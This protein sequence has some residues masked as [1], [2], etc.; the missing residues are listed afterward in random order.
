MVHKQIVII[1]WY[2]RLYL[3]YDIEFVASKEYSRSSCS[4]S[5]SCLDIDKKV[6]HASRGR[7]APS[8]LPLALLNQARCLNLIMEIFFNNH[9]TRVQYSLL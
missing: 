7:E 6:Q 9:F 1:L 3:C 4:L 5:N 8:K 2:L